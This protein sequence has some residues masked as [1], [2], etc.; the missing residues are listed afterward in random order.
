MLTTQLGGPTPNNRSIFLTKYKLK[1][2]G[3]N[4]THPLSNGYIVFTGNY[5]TYNPQHWRKYEVDLDYYRS[6]AN[7][8]F[9]MVCNEFATHNGLLDH[10]SCLSILQ[11]ILHG[12]QVVLLHEP[13]FSNTTTLFMQE[14]IS[15]HLSKFIILEKCVSCNVFSEFPKFIDYNLS[16]SEKQ[17]IKIYVKSHFR[18]LLQ[19]AKR[20]RSTRLFVTKIQ[21]HVS[22]PMRMVPAISHA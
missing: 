1:K 22:I 13:V 2:A 4:V 12:K 17:L 15:K 16:A 18:F 9:H 3:I 14:L 19:P 10:D 11:A 21:P 7:S 5:Y 20:P 6:I 8:D